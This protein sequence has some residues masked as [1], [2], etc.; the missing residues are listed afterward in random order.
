MMK[1]QIGNLS[2]YATIKGE[3]EPVILLHGFTGDH[4]TWK[5]LQSSLQD[6]FLVIAIDIIGHGQ[7]D[8][9]SDLTQ[10]KM[11]EVANQIVQ[12]MDRLEIG[13]AHLLGYSMGGRLALSV[14]MLYPERIKSLLLES[15]SPGLRTKEE[16]KER[17]QKDELLA[18]KISK[19]GVKKFVQLWEKIPLFAS[20]TRLPDQVQQQIRT[21]RLRNNEIGLANSLKGMGT[22][23]QPSWWDRLDELHVPTLLICGELDLKFC[24]IAK[25]M[26]KLLPNPHLV[27]VKGV[28]HAIHVEEPSKFDTIVRNFLLHI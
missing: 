6:S 21:Q 27:Q 12:I 20:Q 16:R 11:S 4:T 3:G 13:Q 22:G 25:E 5:S 14:A 7:T 23:K 8:S 24:R 9:P 15:S 26:K 10:Y 2:Y 17:I 1:M 19:E 28:G 18:Q